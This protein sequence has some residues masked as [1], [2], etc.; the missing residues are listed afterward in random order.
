MGIYSISPSNLITKR[1]EDGNEKDLRQQVSLIV[2][3]ISTY[4]SAQ[5][6][7]EQ[8]QLGL[9]R[10]FPRSVLGG[11]WNPGEGGRSRNAGA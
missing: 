2:G 9:P 10:Q 4:N 1:I 5:V 6:E 7:S 8:T 11:H 3:M